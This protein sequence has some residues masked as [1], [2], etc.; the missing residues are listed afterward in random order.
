MPRQAA[1]ALPICVPSIEFVCSHRTPFYVVS[2]VGCVDPSVRPMSTDR[3]LIRPESAIA[4][5]IK[6][7]VGTVAH[8]SHSRAAVALETSSR[9]PR[10]WNER[11]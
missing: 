1:D 4:T 11:S 10:R 6:R 5:V 7:A 9:L 2:A 3:Y 8:G